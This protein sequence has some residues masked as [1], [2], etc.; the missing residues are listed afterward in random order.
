MYVSTLGFFLASAGRVRSADLPAFQPLANSIPQ[1]TT[2]PDLCSL[3]S[4]LFL[5]TIGFAAILAVI[6]VAIGGFQYMGSDSFSTKSAAKERITD[7]IIGLMIIL[8]SVLL[9]TTINPNLLE[10]CPLRNAPNIQTSAAPPAAGPGGGGVQPG[11]NPNQFIV[12]RSCTLTQVNVSSP[13]CLCDQLA[14]GPG[15]AVG[16]FVS[17]TVITPASPTGDE[18][19]QCLY[20][21]TGQNTPPGTP[22]PPVGSP[23]PVGLGGPPL[24]TAPPAP[25]I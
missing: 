9:L 18:V 10:L 8:G 23:V 5:V 25:P 4:A 16:N 17:R 13:V 22:V 12:Q 11:P 6:M 21:L 1:I 19:F 20:Q 24:P 3:L 15:G 2:S 7:A 14:F